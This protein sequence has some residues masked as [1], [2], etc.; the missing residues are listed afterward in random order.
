MK[1]NVSFGA[2]VSSVLLVIGAI[3]LLQTGSALDWWQG[4]GFEDTIAAPAWPPSA[5]VVTMVALL[6]FLRERH[7][8]QTHL[9][10]I[11]RTLDQRLSD[12]TVDL[13]ND[14]ELLRNRITELEQISQDLTNAR[15]AAEKASDAK[16][17]FLVNMSHELRTPM[18]AILGF[19]DLLSEPSLI[20]EDRLHAIATVQRNG[21]HLIE[22]V[23]DIID[24]S[25]IESG[26]L[27]VDR[28]P[29]SPQ[30]IVAQ[31]AS[32][33]R[34]QAGNK[35]LTLKVEYNGLIPKT[36]QTDARRLRQILINLIN[37]SIKFTKEGGV[38]LVVSM[39]SEPDDA[40][41]VICFEVID[42]GVG[43]TRAQL[44]R[45]FDAFAKTDPA[46]SQQFGGTGLGLMISKS[47]A[48]LLDGDVTIRS[49][50]GMGSTFSVT[51]A[52]GSLKGVEM[53]P[54]P[55][56]IDPGDGDSDT[57]SVEPIQISGRVLLAEDGPDNQW[58]ISYLLR[59]AG[60]EIMVVPD[61]NAAYEQ[62]MQS[63]ERGQPFDV[64]LMDMQM[65]VMDGFSATTKLRTRGY[66]APIVAVTAQSMKGDR[67]RCLAV[68]CDEYMAK[69]IDKTGLLSML[70]RFMAYE[71]TSVSTLA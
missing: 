27:T 15:V 31:V 1:S 30:D 37:N 40:N 61:G 56:E 35:G 49:A 52:T 68:G 22:I 71:P 17:Q 13:E 58:L 51:I 6:A 26:Q 54:D 67:E 59:D 62:A 28:S 29:C 63:Q 47:L 3:V 33:M 5:I 36:V 2:V 43:M 65:P 60:V 57:V 41:P 9:T 34:A 24:L 50:P 23:D 69:P 20:L 32:L 12:R 18:N 8:T 44:A 70:R 10:G 7:Q 64:I 45:A 25:K 55:T 53:I 48:R 19:A 39:A 14:N 4:L 21:R 38:R 42:T 66:T 16:S 11:H 46:T